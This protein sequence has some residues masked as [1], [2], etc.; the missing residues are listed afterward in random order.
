MG[1]GLSSFAILSCLLLSSS[2]SLIF[3]GSTPDSDHGR[4]LFVS[5]LK[6]PV[7]ARVVTSTFLFPKQLASTNLLGHAYPTLDHHRLMVLMSEVSISCQHICVDISSRIRYA[8]R[9]HSRGFAISDHVSK[10]DQVWKY[11]RDLSRC[12]QSL[13]QLWK[14]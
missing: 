14:T 10:S 13:D 9:R 11:M 3:G 4:L 5:I 1:L 6:I 12:Y 8:T 7:A 2:Y